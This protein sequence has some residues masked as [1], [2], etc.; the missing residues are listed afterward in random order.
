MKT[1]VNGVAIHYRIEGPE[2]APVVTLSHAL[3]A[4]LG[5]WDEQ[6]RVLASRY[7]VLRFDTRGH[8]ASEAPPGPYTLDMLAGDVAA[9]LDHLGIAQTHFVGLSMGGMI[10]QTLALAR[11][12]LVASLVLSDTTPVVPESARVQWQARIEAVRRDGME[13]QV[14]ATLERWL[15]PG[16]RA[17]AAETVA[18][19]EAMIRATPVD[20]FIGCCQALMELDV[21]DRLSEIRGPTLVIVGAED[22]STPVEV[23]R[24]LH[25]RIAGSQLCIIK[26]ARHLPNVEQAEAFNARLMAFLESVAGDG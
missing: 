19:I 9:L 7:R 26:G 24:S 11:P 23:A 20:G 12:D 22:P 5:L 14:A 13:S 21:V 4:H 16:F 6:V 17:R 3:A 1:S 15:T 2:A 8:G 25:E 10:G 18:A